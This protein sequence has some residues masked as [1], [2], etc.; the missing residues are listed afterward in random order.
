MGIDIEQITHKYLKVMH[1]Q[2]TTKEK[3]LLRGV[4]LDDIRGYALLWS[5][6]ESLSK[7]IRTGMTID[8]SLLEVSTLSMKGIREFAGTF[9]RFGQYQ[10]VSCYLGDYVV[11]ITLP[12]QS[13]FDF[14]QARSLFWNLDEDRNACRSI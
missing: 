13:T 10:A 6:K 2:V 11:S 14:C 7:V 12:K 9:S 3:A 5:M 1:D 8:L 4:Q